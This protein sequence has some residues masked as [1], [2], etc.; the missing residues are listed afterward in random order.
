MPLDLDLDERVTIGPLKDIA[1][2]DKLISRNS[3]SSK[4]FKKYVGSF[5]VTFST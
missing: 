2:W 3:C 5:L 4:P 1:P